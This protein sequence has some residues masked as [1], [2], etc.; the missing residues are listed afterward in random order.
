MSLLP[1]ILTIGLFDGAH[2]MLGALKQ[3]FPAEFNT[4]FLV[5]PGTNAASQ[6]N[7]I[8][9]SLFGNR[10]KKFVGRAIPS[11][12]ISGEPLNLRG[13]AANI[14]I[15]CKNVPAFQIPRAKF[16]YLPFYVTS[17]GER[18]KNRPEDLLM[19]K[20]ATAIAATKTKFCAFLYSKENAH[21]NRMF[22]SLTRGVAT[23]T[24]RT[25]DALGKCRN[26]NPRGV[27]AAITDRSKL[28]YNDLAVQKYKPYKFVIACENTRLKG[29]ITEK[30]VSAMLAGAIPIYYGAPDIAE[31]FNPKSFIDASVVGW[32][33]QVL[34]LDRNPELYKQMLAEPWC[35]GGNLNRYF[36][37]KHILEG[38]LTDVKIL[39]PSPP[40]H[41]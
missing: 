14:L 10:H 36:D 18:Y 15:D 25:V 3:V 39:L 31:H 1:P 19:L 26:R 20:D 21:R 16:Y 40:Q 6:L 9:Y 23:G 7:L 24:N 4:R 8:I 22:D 30:I 35:V 11:I 2:F 5:N 38:V 37:V 12:C 13:F 17:F 29:Y 34:E 27:A 32:E 41:R 33:K 28:A